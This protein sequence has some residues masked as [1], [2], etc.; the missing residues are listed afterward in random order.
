MPFR[1]FMPFRVQK[2]TQKA[3]NHSPLRCCSAF[4]G[5][6]EVYTPLRGAAYKKQTHRKVAPLMGCSA[7]SLYSFLLCCSAA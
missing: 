5:I 1:V 2:R 4:S 3:A 7:E 6:P